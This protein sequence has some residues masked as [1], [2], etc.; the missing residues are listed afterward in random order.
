MQAKDIMTTSVVTVSPD[1]TVPEIAKLLLERRI[2]AVPVIGE[3]GQLLGMVSEG[4]LM[5]RSEN[6]T[7]RHRSWWL[8]LLDAPEQTAF[9]YIKSHGRHASDVM[10]RDIVTV[11]EDAMLEEIADQLEK[12]RIKRMPVLR[13]GKMLGIVSRADL[14]HG[15]VARRAAPAS[16]AKDSEIRATAQAALEE[17]GVR[18]TFVTVVVA[19]G[20]VQLWGAVDSNAE[21]QAARVAAEGVP[22]VK[23]VDNKIAVLPPN[24]RAAD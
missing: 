15:L 9:D 10:T 2:S 8:G 4:D 5:R 23:G 20:V 7:E 1:T 3:A 14:L 12:H 18:S 17:A 22:G 19:D 6:E 13:D 24:V 21:K 16:T 11:G